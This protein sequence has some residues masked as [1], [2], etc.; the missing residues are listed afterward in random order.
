MNTERRKRSIERTH[1]IAI[2]IAALCL[3]PAFAA[4]AAQP[5]QFTDDGYFILDGKPR[6]ILGMYEN[7]KDDAKLRELAENG[8]N[9]VRVS[10]NTNDLDRVA[11]HGLYAWIP[12]GSQLALPENDPKARDRLTQTIEK[13]KNHPALL[14]WE[15]P[16]EALWNVWYRRY[17]WI[18]NEQPAHLKKLIADAKANHPADKIQH[19]QTML[20]KAKNY[21]NRGLWKQGDEIND[22]LWNELGAKNPHPEWNVSLAEAQARQLGEQ[23][24]RGWNL[25]RETDPSH[26]LWQNH[27]PR[28][29][30]A[31]MRFHNRAVHA[32][33]CDIYP[34]PFNYGV[35]HSDLT[36]MNLTSVGAYTDRMR[37]AAPGKAVWMVLQGFGW[38]DIQDP[39]NP[40]DPKR[41]RRP[42]FDETRFMA[43]NAILHGA[44]AV[45]YWGTH[46][47][48]KNSQLWNDLM[49]VARQIRALEPAIVGQRPP[50]PPTAQADETYASWDGQGPN[51]MLRKTGPYWVLIA[52][53]EGPAGLA[54][55]VKNLPPE[56]NGKTLYRL[57][58]DEKHVVTDGQF[59][60]GIRAL[61]VHVY[62][63]NRQFQTP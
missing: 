40:K 16:D 58:S 42:D 33:G 45:L 31:A 37:A 60:D 38:T 27:A 2:W 18:E 4:R 5:V 10:A 34:A 52:A 24:T 54:F 46:S 50:N 32:A 48:E 20:K 59:R 17:L 39:Y 56:L 25:V 62:A 9:F 15:A 21:M 1:W 57:Y 36:D 44:N 12:L 63:T 41:G 35:R 30:I 7:P 47:I 6:L 29:S 11:K 3:L 26:V 13:F 55:Q 19:W 51:L 49:T 8:F 14:S 22:A 53:N 43:Y 23:L 28:N 61:D